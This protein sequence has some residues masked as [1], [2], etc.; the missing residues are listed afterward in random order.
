MICV[1]LGGVESVLKK[2][3]EMPIYWQVLLLSML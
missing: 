1:L 3:D 2:A